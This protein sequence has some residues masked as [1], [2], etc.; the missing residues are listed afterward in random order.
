MTFKIRSKAN[1]TLFDI[2]CFNDIFAKAE[3][4]IINDLLKMD[5][6]QESQV[7]QSRREECFL[8]SHHQACV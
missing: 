5:L 7:E 8:F 4:D 6:L 3:V 2:V 1:S